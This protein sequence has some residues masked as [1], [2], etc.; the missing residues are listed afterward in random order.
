MSV[1]QPSL[2]AVGT[3][4]HGQHLYEPSD[5]RFCHLRKISHF[6]AKRAPQRGARRASI[7][8]CPVTAAV[9]R[10]DHGVVSAQTF[11]RWRYPL[12]LSAFRDADDR[13]AGHPP[14]PVS[15]SRSACRFTNTSLPAKCSLPVRGATG[16]DYAGPQLVRQLHRH[17]PGRRPRRRGSGRSG[18][19]LVVVEEALPGGQPGD[20]HGGGH[21][22]VNVRRKLGE[23]AGLHRRVLGQRP[24]AG[25]VGQPEHPLAHGQAG[26]TV[27]QLAELAGDAA[28]GACDGVL[29]FCDRRGRQ[30]ITRMPRPPPRRSPPAARPRPLRRSRYRSVTPAGPVS[31]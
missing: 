23:V 31:S 6:L 16:A 17:G 28:D 4:G 18:R 15:S 24:V 29:A 27:A 9:V 10:C 21:G 26:G 3:D 22:V 5:V 7:N 2:E 19:S 20:G 12:P 14:S 8:R 11:Q 1:Q 25:P 30:L 13:L